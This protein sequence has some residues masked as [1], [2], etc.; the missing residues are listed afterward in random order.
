[1]WC[2]IDFLDSRFTIPNYPSRLLSYL[3]AKIPVICATDSNTDVGKIAQDNG[4]GYWYKSEETADFIN[5]VNKMLA[6]NISEMGEKGYKYLV[7]NYL[8]GHTCQTI[9]NHFG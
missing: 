3:A 2:G 9:L 7:N 6:S 4:Y 5:L 1:M 8:V